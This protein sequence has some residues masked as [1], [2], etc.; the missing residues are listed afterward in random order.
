MTE[1]QS[2]GDGLDGVSVAVWPNQQMSLETSW[3]AAGT[4]L[5]CLL[6]NVGIRTGRALAKR[7]IPCCS[8]ERWEDRRWE[9]EKIGG[10]EDGEMR[11][12]NQKGFVVLETKLPRPGKPHSIKVQLPLTS[13]SR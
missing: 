1:V 13:S 3:L 5:S 11:F 2:S 8:N 10:R 7:A 6:S 9:D 12:L 4:L